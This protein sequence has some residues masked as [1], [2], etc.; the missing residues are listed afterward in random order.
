MALSLFAR[1][2]F[3]LSVTLASYTYSAIELEPG[4]IDTCFHADSV[5]ARSRGSIV[6]HM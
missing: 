2:D 1:S 5:T 4:S 6:S 3:R